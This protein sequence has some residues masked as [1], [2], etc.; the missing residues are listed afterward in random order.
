MR[1]A[2]SLLLILASAGCGG[3]GSGLYLDTDVR[4]VEGFRHSSA[5]E[6]QM[7]GGLMQ[8]GTLEYSGTG[9]IKDV[10]RDYVADMKDVGWVI[11]HVDVQGDKA[12]GTLR[13][14]N[15]T[16]NLEFVKSADKI[17]ATIRVGATK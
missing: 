11:A 13:K 14:D 5:K 8:N 7:S 1:H 2:T 10:F 6:I 16:C 4:E 9:E 3:G 12:V 15:R 17:R